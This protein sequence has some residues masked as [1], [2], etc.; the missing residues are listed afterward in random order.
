M[1]GIK[2][3]GPSLDPSGYGA[4]TR[5]YIKAGYYS[6]LFDITVEPWNFEEKEGAFYG[7]GG[8]LV[9]NL[10]NRNIDY[11]SVFIH[12]VPNVIEGFVEP[13]KL[14][15]G[16]STW[17]TNIIPEHWIKNINTCFDLQLVPSEYNKKAYIECGLTKPIEVVPHCVNLAEIDA[18][19]PAELP[20]AF[21][22]HFVF[23]SVF[24]WTERKNPIG[25]LKAYFSEFYK[26]DD[27]VLI[28]KSYKSDSSL[29]EQNKIKYE[30][31]KLKQDMKLPKYPKINFIGD[32]IP[33]RNIIEL[34]KTSNCF[35]LPTRC[36]GFGMPILEAMACYLPVIT[37][38]YGGGA[39]LLYEGASE[40]SGFE[41]PVCGMNWISYY[42]ST[43]VWAEPSIEDVRFH[44]RRLYN[45]ERFLEE[46]QAARNKALEYDLYPIAETLQ[47]SIMKHGG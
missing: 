32:L 6:G 9:E 2:W 28:L 7:D 37:T 15:I 40:I 31:E 11:S 38:N 17:E 35:V 33:Y 34:Y 4:A 21:K 30:I 47:N 5:D 16:Y 29:F 26:N 46:V 41:T 20:D 1:I 24:Q 18:I 39:E 23:I 12:C 27:V 44:M 14:N 3:K 45:G 42:D 10:K 43:Q 36:E 22:D 25:L 8:R 19:S 13:G